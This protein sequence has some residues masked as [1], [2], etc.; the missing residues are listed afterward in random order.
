[1]NSNMK[2]AGT[3]LFYGSY[4][5]YPN[6]QNPPQPPPPLQGSPHLLNKYSNILPLPLHQHNQQQQQQQVQLP[7]Q[8]Q[9]QSQH[10]SPQSYPPAGIPLTGANVGSANA[11]SGFVMN[12]LLGNPSINEKS[13]FNNHL[14]HRHPPHHHPQHN[15]L[16]TPSSI[17]TPA[18]SV[19]ATMSA[20]SKQDRTTGSGPNDFVCKKSLLSSR[21]AAHS[22]PLF[23]FFLSL[24]TGQKTLL[25]RSNNSRTHHAAVPEA[26]RY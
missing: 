13:Q 11:S 25:V 15:P 19:A 22:N 3:G 1:M 24:D 12:Q 9:P 18:D 5:E 6:L 14:Q 2:T 23:Y 10:H 26:H 21:D 4:G 8:Q 7:Q 16:L 17:M 20:A